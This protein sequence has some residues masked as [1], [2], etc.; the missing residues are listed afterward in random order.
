MKKHTMWM[1]G[2]AMLAAGGLQAGEGLGYQDTPIITGTSYHVHDG[3]RP[4]PRIIETAGA[5]VVTPPSD[6]TILF[7]GK[8]LDAWTTDGGEAVWEIKDGAMVATKKAISTKEKFGAIQLHVEWRLPAERK[9][10]GQKGG[11][12]GIFLM[13]R[14]EVQVLQSHNNK[15]Y[16]DGQAGALYGQL[17]PLVNA[18]SP[19]G[20]WNS[21]DIIFVPPVYEGDSVKTPAKVTII[22]NG[23]VVQNAESYLGPT[24]HKKLASYPKTHP[25]TAPIGLQFHGDPMEYRNIWVRPLG[26]R[27]QPN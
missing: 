10:N 5:V 15:T 6:A 23:V 21:Y 19:Q 17:P 27:D 18:T 9:V 8:N 16:P 1:F 20:E 11:N 13:G 22:H 25:D 24:S 7:D 3:E 14:Y 2:G 12:S 26:E 4:Q